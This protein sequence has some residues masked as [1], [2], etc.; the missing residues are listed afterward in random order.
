M[1]DKNE[2]K[3]RDVWRRAREEYS[4]AG[5]LYPELRD[6]FAVVDEAMHVLDEEVARV[7]D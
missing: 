1:E 2:E 5:A 4:R 3:R 7:E 6:H